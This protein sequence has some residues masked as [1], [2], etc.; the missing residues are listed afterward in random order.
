MNEV[1][2]YYK[3]GGSGRKRFSNKHDTLLFYAKKPNALNFRPQIEK[4]Y[5][6]GMRPYRFKGVREYRDELGWYTLVGMKDV[7]EI[8]MVGRTSKERT[9]YASQKPIALLERIVTA[10]TGEGDLCIDLFG[11]SGTLAAA[12]RHTG[13]RW[14][15]ADNNPLAAAITEKRLSQIPGKAFVLLKEKEAYEDTESNA[16]AV[17]INTAGATETETVL[18]GPGLSLLI[19]SYAPGKNAFAGLSDM[20]RGHVAA[21]AAFDPSQFIALADVIERAGGTKLRL[22]DI[23]GDEAVLPLT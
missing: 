6:R 19:E 17:E 23:F 13:R 8:P 22:V 21:A 4:S 12:A 1:I 16:P 7:W 20:E 18:A 11:G 2:W 10:C 5:N 3:S 14:I 15:T 9:G